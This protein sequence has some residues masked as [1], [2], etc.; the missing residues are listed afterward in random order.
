MTPWSPQVC[1]FHSINC[2][3]IVVISGGLHPTATHAVL[4]THSKLK[5]HPKVACVLSAAAAAPSRSR[6]WPRWKT[7]RAGP[8]RSVWGWML[9]SA[10]NQGLAAPSDG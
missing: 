2:K 5:S 6:T 3:W 8:N 1:F 4:I 7:A 10:G 9:A